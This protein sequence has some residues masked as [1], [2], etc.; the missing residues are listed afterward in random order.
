MYFSVFFLFSIVPLLLSTLAL[1][2]LVLYLHPFAF[3]EKQAP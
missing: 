2:Y 1:F 3:S